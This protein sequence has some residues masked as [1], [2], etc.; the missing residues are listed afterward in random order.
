MAT[1]FLISL[2]TR[3]LK[4]AVASFSFASSKYPMN[5]AANVFSGPRHGTQFISSG[6]M[7]EWCG[8]LRPCTNHFLQQP[9]RQ[10]AAMLI[11]PSR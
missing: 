3:N 8:P 1:N 2:G 11:Q 9:S 7:P 10:I 6:V 5:S 4:R